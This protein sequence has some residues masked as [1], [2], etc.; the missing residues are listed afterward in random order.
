[1]VSVPGLDH[2]MGH[3]GHLLF[4]SAICWIAHRV[5]GVLCSTRDM[6][7]LVVAQS[8]LV[9]CLHHVVSRRGRLVAIHFS[10][11][12]STLASRSRRDAAGDH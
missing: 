3:L 1:M 6:A 2:H 4:Q 11:S 12:L 10:L 9:S 7:A 5:G 8:T